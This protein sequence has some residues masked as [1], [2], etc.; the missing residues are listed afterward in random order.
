MQ[1]VERV[2]AEQRRPHH[3][4]ERDD[5]ADVGLHGLGGCPLRLHQAQAQLAAAAA[6]GGDPAAAPAPT[7]GRAASDGHDVEFRLPAEAV[8][9]VRPERRRPQED[10]SGTATPGGAGL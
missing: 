5:R 3:L 4:A 9:C 7:A 10:D 2:G 1:V 8:Q 6:T